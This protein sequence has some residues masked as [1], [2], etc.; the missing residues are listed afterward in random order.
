MIKV[1]CLDYDNTVFDHRAG[2]I[3]ESA[4]KALEAVR[5]KCRIVLAS[6]RF[7]NDVWN[8][9]IKEL[10]KPDGIIHSNGS[11]VEAEGLVL[12]ET[13][14]D[15]K[16][17][18]EV[19]DFA[20]AHELCLG[21]LYEGKWYTT[22]PEKQLSRWKGKEQLFRRELHDAGM[23]YEIPMHALY[24][25]DTVE[26]ARLIAENFP[27]LRTP[28][29]NEITGGADV[30]PSYLSKA[31]GL[32]LLLKHWG[33]GFAET[34]AVG[35]SMNDLEMIQ[36]A[37]VGIAMGNGVSALKEAADFVT[38]DISEDGLKRALEYLELLS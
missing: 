14:L 8:A 12:K 34:A 37:G 3:P 23:L 18:K 20:Y 15:P 35:D 38:A 31:Y 27:G 16:L 7:F 33:L 21:G 26:A 22:N 10:I 6:G 5:G 13:F 1:L 11:M 29:M 24:L 36:A 19:L 28:L 4:E 9:P 2:K 32:T 25:D 30:I 17:Q